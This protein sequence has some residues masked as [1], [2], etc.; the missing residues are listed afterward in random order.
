MYKIHM[1]THV[2]H[3]CV[4]C[5]VSLDTS[6]LQTLDKTMQDNFER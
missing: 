2:L 5:D 4:Q 3:P 6:V 1:L